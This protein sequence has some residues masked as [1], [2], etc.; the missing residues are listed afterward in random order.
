MSEQQLEL[1][2]IKKS[3][4]KVPPYQLGKMLREYHKKYL[5][6][7]PAEFYAEAVKI[8]DGGIF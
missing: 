5:D 8:F 7:A 1:H 3:I 2:K 6:N 4:G